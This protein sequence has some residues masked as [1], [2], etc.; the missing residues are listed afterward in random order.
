MAIREL[1][2]AVMYSE[3]IALQFEH[4][5]EKYEH[6]AF[7]LAE[8]GWFVTE[9]FLPASLITQLADET[10][11]LF[12]YNQFQRAGVGCGKGF[13]IKR[14]VR[15]DWI[16][17]LNLAQCTTAQLQY[18][19]A[20]EGLRQ[21]INRTLYLGLFEFEAHL[22]IYSPGCYYREHLDQFK[23]D[24]RR[25]VTCVLYLNTNWRSSDGGQLRLFTN[26]ADK[27]Q[28]EEILPIGGRMVCFLSSR[29]LH[30]VMT[31]HDERLSITGWFKSHIPIS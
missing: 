31:A 13:S 27:Q 19:D 12:S 25:L 8:R 18:M 17:W 14:E 3:E 2:Y 5:V 16:K 21:T 9:D 22:A 26:P 10:R 1:V 29:F 23:D 24:G 6:L 4:T 15:S 20:L 28:Y 30:A 7:A 11:E